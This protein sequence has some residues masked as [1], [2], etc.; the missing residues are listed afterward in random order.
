[1]VQRNVHVHRSAR[2]GNFYLPIHRPKGELIERM[3]DHG[4]ARKSTQGQIKNMEVVKVFES[5]PHT[6]Q[7]LLVERQD[8]YTLEWPLARVFFFFRNFL[9]L[10]TR[11]CR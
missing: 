7:L 11:G 4:I 2:S 1:M 10:S 3:Y 8:F 6:R 5:R 9:E